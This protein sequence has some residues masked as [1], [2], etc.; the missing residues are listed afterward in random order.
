MTH[1]KS[2]LN[3]T[4]LVPTAGQNF[5]LAFSTFAVRFQNVG[6]YNYVCGL[7]TRMVGRVIPK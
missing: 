6:T 1:G 4:G 7:H 5:F 2:T 3:Q